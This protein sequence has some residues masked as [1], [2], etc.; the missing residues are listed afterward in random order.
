[1]SETNQQENII[2]NNQPQNNTPAINDNQNHSSPNNPVIHGRRASMD[3]NVFLT[4][5]LTGRRS[6]IHP[7]Q[8]FNNFNSH[9]EE[10]LKLQKELI[11]S[12]QKK[13]RKKNKKNV[14]NKTRNNT[15]SSFNSTK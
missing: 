12:N 10:D 2:S 11:K 6:S 15:K 7:F 14:R 13:K 5:K 1:M 8:N 9:K 4:S 3:T